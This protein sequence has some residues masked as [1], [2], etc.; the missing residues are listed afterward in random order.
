MCI[1]I[2]FG[3]SGLTVS[4]E[5]PDPATFQY[6]IMAD[7]KAMVLIKNGENISCANCALGKWVCFN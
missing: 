1:G 7:A 6:G 3:S 4:A 5:K 2:G